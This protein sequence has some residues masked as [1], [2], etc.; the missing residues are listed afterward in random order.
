VSQNA[1]YQR[2]ADTD[3]AGRIRVG[4]VPGTYA[5]TIVPPSSE[6]GIFFGEWTVD[7]DAGG[8][9][10]GFQLPRQPKVSGE[11]RAPTGVVVPLA[12]AV[13][14]PS[15]DAGTSY[16][17]AVLLPPVLQ[18]RRVSGNVDAEGRFELS[19][20]PGIF[21][22]AIET[23]AARGFPWLVVPS[24]LVL[25]ADQTPVLQLGERSLAYPAIVEGTLDIA[26][27]GVPY[28][29]VRA[30]VEVPS[31]DAATSRYVAVGE[32]TTDELGGFFLPLPPTLTLPATRP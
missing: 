6:M 10:I 8:N 7:D 29:I 21:D 17:D 11:V 13:A 2:I 24:L 4:L 22:L 5:V 3:D 16:L 31:A 14:A 12:P 23:N 27:R 30:W 19:L 1:G 20:D 9:G 32:T 26:G 18:P 25:P 28:A 15:L